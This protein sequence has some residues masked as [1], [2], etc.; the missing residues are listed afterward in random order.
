MPSLVVD[1]SPRLASC[2]LRLSFSVC[3]VASVVLAVCNCSSAASHSATLA[4]YF[5]WETQPNRPLVIE[6]VIVARPSHLSIRAIVGLHAFECFCAKRRDNRQSDR[7]GIFCRCEVA[8]ARGRNR[9][10]RR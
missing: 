1:A 8:N 6:K 5:S 10:K 9:K 2:C 7:I 4:L 3:N